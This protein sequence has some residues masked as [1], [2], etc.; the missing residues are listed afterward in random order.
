MTDKPL[1]S[2]PAYPCSNNNGINHLFFL[3]RRRRQHIGSIL[4]EICQ[5]SFQVNSP[6]AILWNRLRAV[7]SHQTSDNF[8]RLPRKVA[9]RYAHEK[10]FVQNSARYTAAIILWLIVIS[11]MLEIVCFPT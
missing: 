11:V 2:T 4:W 7:L 3:L 9:F 5:A 6:L 8:Q 10:L 1:Y